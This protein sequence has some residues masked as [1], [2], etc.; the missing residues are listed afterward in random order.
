MKA[1]LEEQRQ[2]PSYV[3]VRQEMIT[4]ENVDKFPGW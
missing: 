4:K 3:Q 1:L 2:L